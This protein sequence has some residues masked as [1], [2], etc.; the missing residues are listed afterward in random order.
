MQRP[1]ESI[2]RPLPLCRLIRP[3]IE[4]HFHFPNALRTGL[5]AGTVSMAFF[6]ACEY[7]LQLETEGSQEVVCDRNRN[8]SYTGMEAQ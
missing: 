4:V 1:G 8:E 6:S 7:S 3:V 2:S 5:G